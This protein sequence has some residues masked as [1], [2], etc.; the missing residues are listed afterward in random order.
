M[1]ITREDAHHHQNPVG[2]HP[3]PLLDAS[4][5]SIANQSKNAF[6]PTPNS[7]SNS[8]NPFKLD[9]TSN[10]ATETNPPNIALTRLPPSL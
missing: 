1:L 4:T 10:N 3:S 8:H 7:A 9:T 5:P 2:R 6:P